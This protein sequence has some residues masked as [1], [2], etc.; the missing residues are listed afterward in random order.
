[1][2]RERREIDDATLVGGGSDGALTAG[3][4]IQSGLLVRGEQRRAEPADQ[5]KRRGAALG[6][7]S[8]IIGVSMAT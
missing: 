6:W 4:S 3:I 8:P 2:R 7:R 5:I 1:M